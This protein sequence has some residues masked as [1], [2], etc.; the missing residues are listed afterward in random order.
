M[1]KDLKKLLSQLPKNRAMDE[2]DIYSSVA[3][4]KIK[5]FRGIF[6]RNTLPKKPRID[7]CAVVNLDSSEGPGTH[8]VAYCK[9]QHKVYYFDSFGNL[10]PPLE[11]I[12]YFGNN[13]QIYYNHNNYQ[14]FNTFICGQL[15]VHDIFA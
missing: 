13:A 8:W 11:V 3:M 5:H 2:Y 7:E 14:N 9:R 4:L 6:M 15:C 1:S 12:N 10:P